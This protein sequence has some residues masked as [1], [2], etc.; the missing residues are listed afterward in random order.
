MLTWFNSVVL[1]IYRQLRLLV[2]LFPVDEIYN[3]IRPL[4]LML[5]DN[6]VAEIRQSSLKAVRDYDFI[7][8]FFKS[9]LVAL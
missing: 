2:D 1:L 4:A 9:F 7:Y 6:H 3:C 5:S 8:A